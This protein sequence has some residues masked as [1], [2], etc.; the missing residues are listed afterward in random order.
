MGPGPF[1][2]RGG[3]R[4]RA[5]RAWVGVQAS[6]DPYAAIDLAGGSSGPPACPVTIMVRNDLDRPS[7]AGP[8]RAIAPRVEPRPELP[9]SAT[10][11]ATYVGILRETVWYS[12]RIAWLHP[13]PG[14]APAP[15][16]GGPRTKAGRSAPPP[17]PARPRSVAAGPTPGGLEPVAP[18]MSRRSQRRPRP[19]AGVVRPSRTSPDQTCGSV[20]AGR[21]PSAVPQ[22]SR[23]DLLPV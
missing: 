21:R 5:R 23:R 3:V 11:A 2:P 16:P 15:G 18:A 7:P 10:I 1:A 4:V 14:A 19:G 6:Q 13:G 20:P 12:R 17:R 8:R 9:A 22:P